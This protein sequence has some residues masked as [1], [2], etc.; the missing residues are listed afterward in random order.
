VPR[1]SRLPS[2]HALDADTFRVLTAACERAFRA[3]HGRKRV[4]PNEELRDTCLR[5]LI[6]VVER[7]QRDPTKLRAYAI[8]FLRAA[9][10]HKRG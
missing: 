8:T 4:A 10:S 3:V 1:W 5:L 6:G 7:G 9:I 2:D